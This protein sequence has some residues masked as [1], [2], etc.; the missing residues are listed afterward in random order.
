MMFRNL[1]WA[2]SLSILV[3]FPASAQ[4]NQLR[5]LSQPGAS[6]LPSAQQQLN[7]NLGQQRSG[8]S[9]QRRIEGNNRL[10]RTNQINR[11]NS[12]PSP[13]CPGANTSCLNIR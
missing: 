12:D 11:N 2:A 1:F 8:Y 6:R 10:N 13:T 7:Q 9:T 4:N 5:G 3:A